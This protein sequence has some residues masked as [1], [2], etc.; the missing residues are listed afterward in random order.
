[1]IIEKGKACH[2]SVQALWSAVERP[3]WRV[4]I[5]MSATLT[6]LER[7][8]PD[9]L[10][11]LFLLNHPVYQIRSDKRLTPANEYQDA[12]NVTAIEFDD[13][14]YHV[15]FA[16][17]PELLLPAK[18]IC[19]YSEAAIQPSADE[20]LRSFGFH[21]PTSAPEPTK[22]VPSMLPLS[23]QLD[24]IPDQYVI[25]DCEFGT[26]FRRSGSSNAINWQV[27]KTLGLKTSLFQLSA[28]GFDRHQQTTTFFNRYFDNPNFLPE[29][30]LT[31]LAETGLTIT[32]YERQGL[33]LK[34]C[35]AFITQV[36]QL[37]VPLV[38]WDQT[39]DLKYLRRLLAFY[40]PKLSA[41]ERAIVQAPI[42]IF[43]AQAYTNALINHGNHRVSAHGLPLNGL[44]ALFNISNPHQ[45]NAIWD[46]Q[47]IELVLRHLDNQLKQ[48]V[49]QT[50]QPAPLFASAPALTSHQAR[51]PGHA[52]TPAPQRTSRDAKYALVRKLH[53]RG[54]TY[55]EIAA[56][57]GISISGVNYILKKA[58]AVSPNHGVVPSPESV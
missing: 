23:G 8:I 5:T 11:C 31:G 12:G 3:K 44:A 22:S 1:M 39:Q 40:Y 45:H 34:I 55:R 52:L 24:Q 47:T 51:T 48:P 50:V 36:L 56:A 54:K 49:Q 16:H 58:V 41:S 17:R 43:D 46:V 28:I 2:L 9:N 38:F 35:Q 21:I 42:Q 25:L 15:C 30:K 19:R 20:F 32:A 26:L 10:N 29:K 7:Q 57:T 4:V 18:K 27:F 13:Q 37:N 53:A 33:P 6:M 14:R